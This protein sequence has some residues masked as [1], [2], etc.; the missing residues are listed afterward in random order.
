MENRGCELKFERPFLGGANDGRKRAAHGQVEAKTKL[1]AQLAGGS[2]SSAAEAPP[3]FG[4]SRAPKPPPPK[5]AGPPVPPIP[6][7]QEDMAATGSDNDSPE[8]GLP[9]A[10][11]PPG[12]RL[13]VGA[14]S[15]PLGPASKSLAKPGDSD[16]MPKGVAKAP[17][18]D[19]L[20]Q[21]KPS[22]RDA[23]PAA[24]AD[25]PDA[26]S[27][28]NLTM[29]PTPFPKDSP[30]SNLQDDKKTFGAPAEAQHE[31]PGTAGASQKTNPMLT[32]INTR[33]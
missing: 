31:Q 25:A 29:P 33:G 13:R 22:L 26:G 30:R 2:A 6:K 32:I 12:D 15:A 11:P 20:P 18:P 19:I 28:T 8:G 24:P 14:A 1:L 3:R 10:A 27:S 23:P 9:P 17:P 4:V 16:Q 5:S 7:G 21:W